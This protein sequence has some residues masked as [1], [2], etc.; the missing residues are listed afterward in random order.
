MVQKVGCNKRIKIGYNDILDCPIN[1]QCG[2]SKDGNEIMY[3]EDCKRI[4]DGKGNKM[5]A[6]QQNTEDHGGEE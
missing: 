4:I 1:A 6:S 3:C 5:F 2:M